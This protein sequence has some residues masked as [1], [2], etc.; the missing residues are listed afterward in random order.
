MVKH[1][2]IKAAA[3]MRIETVRRSGGIFA[4]ITRELAG[5]RISWPIKLT[6]RHIPYGER[7]SIEPDN[8]GADGERTGGGF[9][10]VIR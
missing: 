10:L 8:V 6:Y 3:W 5:N 9:E 4:M 2:G 1:E 7:H